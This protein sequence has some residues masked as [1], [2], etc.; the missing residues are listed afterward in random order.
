MFVSSA[1]EHEGLAMKI[2][3]IFVVVSLFAMPDAAIAANTNIEMAQAYN[4][5]CKGDVPDFD[6]VAAKAAAK[7]LPVVQHRKMPMPDGNYME[8]EMWSVDDASGTFAVEAI[9]GTN[10]GK[11]MASCSVYFPDLT[12][13]DLPSFLSKEL[14][15]GAPQKQSTSDDGKQT[16]F[17]ATNHSDQRI[18]LASG[19]KGKLKGAMLN[20]MQTLEPGN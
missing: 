9:Q 2:T 5:W 4:N 13:D 12:D 1:L 8:D 20:F 10:K 17:W 15:L 6:V 14:Q 7:N 16:T 3:G 19:S 11:H 18:M